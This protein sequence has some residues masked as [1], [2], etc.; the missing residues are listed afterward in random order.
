MTE[1]LWGGMRVL[2]L[3]QMFDFYCAAAF[4]QGEICRKLKDRLTNLWM[5][6][7]VRFNA[8]GLTSYKDYK[9]E[10]LFFKN[11]LPGKLSACDDKNTF[12]A[13]FA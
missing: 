4:R 7:R 13:K 11:S 12:F 9:S 1:V 8:V 2:M 6:S 10:C 5:D 3:D